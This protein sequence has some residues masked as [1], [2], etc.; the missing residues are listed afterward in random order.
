MKKDTKEKLKKLG[1]HLANK[2]GS[3]FSLR[4]DFIKI[5]K[6]EGLGLKLNLHALTVKKYEDWLKNYIHRLR[7]DSFFS[8]E[9]QIET[10]SLESQIQPIL[11]IDDVKEITVK[12]KSGSIETFTKPE[13]QIWSGL[14]EY[15]QD[16]AYFRTGKYTG[17]NVN[18]S[19]SLRNYF[20]DY[21]DLY[22]YITSCLSPKLLNSISNTRNSEELEMNVKTL[23]ELKEKIESRSQFPTVL[24]QIRRKK[25]LES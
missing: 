11:D 1:L 7:Y 13:P 21:L 24:K 19:Q 6:L 10:V 16:G 25:G 5:S 4:A 15:R 3:D 23:T 22:A 20:K 18:S 17:C 8:A 12:F 14:F 9:P 2:Y